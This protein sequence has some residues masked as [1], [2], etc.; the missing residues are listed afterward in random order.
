MPHCPRLVAESIQRPAILTMASFWACFS[1]SPPPQ[2]SPKRSFVPEQP[3]TLR[4]ASSVR[5][6]NA[7]LIVFISSRSFHGWDDELRTLF[8]ARR[9]ARRHCFC[10]GVEADRIWPMLVEVAEARTFPAAERV[11]RERN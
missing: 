8:D 4:A 11:I 10:L 7:M 1:L 2:K 5:A 6:R 3:A 9:P